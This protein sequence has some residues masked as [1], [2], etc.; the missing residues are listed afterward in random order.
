MKR[1]RWPIILGLS[2]IVLSIV[3]YL[4][5]YAIFRDI[6]HIFIY[7]LGDIAFLPIEVLLVVLIVHR[8][9]SE[10][11]KR[12]RLEK[13]SMVIGAF[14]TEVGTRLLTYFSDLDP[15]LDK[16]RK[17]LIVTNNWSD[18]EFLSVSKRLKNHDYG[19]EIQ[20]V[21]LE[22]LCRFLTGKRN[23]LLRLLENPNL[24]E[25]ETFTDLL[26]AVCHL[27]QELSYRKDFSQLPDT[28][29]EHLAGDIKRVY[30]LLVNEWLGYMKYLK[31][32]YPYLFSL[33][34]RINPFDQKA[35]PIVK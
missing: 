21:N 12:A 1:F 22:D 32:N 34:M 2:L 35:S 3:L 6:H 29:Y 15:K 23:F 8:L 30:I 13:M 4:T 33:A 24:L 28:D 27:T 18:Q 25:H 14:F 19:V 10:R 11:E 7:M 9:L 31:K 5:H 17:E 26:Q 20:K 16:I